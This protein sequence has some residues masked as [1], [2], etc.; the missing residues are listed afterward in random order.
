M[1][2]LYLIRQGRFLLRVHL[3]VMI[4]AAVTLVLFALS[5]P[6]ADVEKPR[7]WIGRCLVLVTA[8]LGVL[9]CLSARSAPYAGQSVSRA[10][11]FAFQRAT[12]GYAADH[13]DIYFVT[14]FIRHNLD[15][16]HDPAA[17]P[18]NMHRWGDNG[19]TVD[20]DR[21]YADAFFR[22]DVQFMYETPSTILALLQYL[23]LDFGPVQAACLAQPA[24][25]T[26][27]VD[28]D[29]VGPGGDYTGWY[30]QNGMTYYFRQGQAL[31]G[32]QTIDGKQYTFAGAGFDGQFTAALSPAGE[33]IYTTTAYSLLDGD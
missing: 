17:Y 5:G 29:Q 13:P 33:P 32:P 31:T 11:A 12:E 3:A 21:L 24:A 26:F 19:A 16:F 9:A 10:E 8:S 30:E 18:E 25:A 28:I 14:N 22:P 15:P 1:L 7:P 23:S 27:V 20:P 6:G 4:P 2:L